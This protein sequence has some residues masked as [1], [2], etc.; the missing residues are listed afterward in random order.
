M[1]FRGAALQEVADFKVRV[2]IPELFGIACGKLCLGYRIEE[3]RII[4]DCKNA[5]ELVGNHD[6]RCAEAVAQLQDQVVE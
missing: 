4:A 2:M 5:R 3:D 1:S 6:N